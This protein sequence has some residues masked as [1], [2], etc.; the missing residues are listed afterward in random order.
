MNPLAVISAVLRRECLRAWR[1]QAEAL[2]PLCFFALVVVL[3]PFALGPD[4]ALLA[5]VA[6]GVVWVAA[7]LAASLSLDAL[8]RADYQDGTL[9]AL[10]AGGAPLLAFALGKALAHWVLSAL[11]V[12]LLSGPV[13]LALDLPGPAV[14]VL[15]AS[16][17]LGSAGMSLV[18]TAVGALTVGVRGSG[19]L[20]A[21]L[22]LPL[23]IP[24]LVFGAAA[25][26]NAARDLAAAAELYFLAG[27]ALLALTLAPWAVA[28]ALRIRLS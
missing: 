28:A 11:P 6:G 25:A 19:M 16:L 10:V 22:I 2:Q 4:A 15:L 20:L 1:S 24:L 3:F 12:L 21:M 26:T 14:V 18:G 5:R 17:A 9:E 23:Y 8:F 7:L 13:A 27:L